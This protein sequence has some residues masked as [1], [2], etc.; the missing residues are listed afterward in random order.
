LWSL[1]VKANEHVD[2]GAVAESTVREETAE[3][4]TELTETQR[5]GDAF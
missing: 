4:Q 1:L 2:V 3:C 5:M